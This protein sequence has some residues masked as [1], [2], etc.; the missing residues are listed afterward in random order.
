MLKVSVFKKKLALSK[1]N[2]R[3]ADESDLRDE[4]V[5]QIGGEMQEH[6]TPYHCLKTL[7]DKSQADLNAASVQ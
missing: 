7:L 5:F 3:L 1:S 4:T 6:L 2:A